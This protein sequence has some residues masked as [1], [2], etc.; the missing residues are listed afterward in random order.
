MPA[1]RCP[2]SAPRCGARTSR[3]ST[4]TNPSMRCSR[5]PSSTGS[6]I[7]IAC[8]AHARGAAAG[9]RARRW[10]R[11][12]GNV[13]RFL[14]TVDRVAAEPPF[15]SYLADFERAWRFAGEEETEARLRATG[16]VE[17]R[18]WLEPNDVSR[19]TPPTFCAGLHFDVTSSGCRR[20]FTIAS[21]EQ[22]LRRCGEPLR[23][24]YIRLQ[25]EARRPV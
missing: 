10:M 3:S 5:T 16:F 2:P 17:A 24:G 20:S 11:R 4:S 23:L 7:R 15:D 18:A 14:A 12:G 19:R 1:T 13:E 9:G 6:S 8:C 22:V 25:I 21:V